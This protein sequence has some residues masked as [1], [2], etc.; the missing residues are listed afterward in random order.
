MIQH[1][2]PDLRRLDCSGHR[3]RHGEVRVVGDLL[4]VVVLV[5]RHLFTVVIGVEIR[6][7]LLFRFAASQQFLSLTLR[8]GVSVILVGLKLLRGDVSRLLPG[9]LLRETLS[10]FAFPLALLSCKTLADD[11]V[12]FFLSEGL[13]RFLFDRLLFRRF[14]FYGFWSR[15]GFQF[16]RGHIR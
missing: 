5:P 14:G 9:L 16:R 11:R 8:Q 10:L 2:G 4:E 12:K 15:R 3:F 6:A 1:V 13:G 7:L